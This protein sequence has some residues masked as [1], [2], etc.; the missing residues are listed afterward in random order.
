M[1]L[2]L[3]VI[4]TQIIGFLIVLGVL[5]AYAWGPILKLLE[6]RRE[7]IRVSFEDIDHQKKEIA[8]LKVQYEDE[9]KKIDALTRQRMNEVV[10]EAHKTAQDIESAARER[11]Q[12]ELTRLKSEIEHEYRSARVRLR[13]EIVTVA[14]NAAERMVREKLDRNRQTALVDEF[15]KDLEKKA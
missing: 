11:S 13:D 15:L 3:A 14:M 9:L 12:A 7:K 5:K 6:E 10:A 8:A 1:N 4:V 2:Q